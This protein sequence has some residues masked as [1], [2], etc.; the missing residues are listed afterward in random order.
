MPP[1]KSG[2]AARLRLLPGPSSPPRPLPF[3]FFFF[4]SFPHA[5]PGRPP[6]P[7]LVRG[8]VFSPKRRRP[9]FAPTPAWPE[10]VGGK[11]EKSPRRGAAPALPSPACHRRGF[12]TRPSFP[13]TR[14]ESGGWASHCHLSRVRGKLAALNGDRPRKTRAQR[15]SSSLSLASLPVRQRARDRLRGHAPLF[16]SALHHACVNAAPPPGLPGRCSSS[17]VS[18]ASS[19]GA[20]YAS[21][22][23]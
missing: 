7:P 18:D 3:F 13:P 12:F 2:S 8:F 16:P 11:A 22:D 10:G 1:L 4:R 21:H 20:A 23:A 5:M 17:S 19:H 6:P 9:P 14:E 15:H